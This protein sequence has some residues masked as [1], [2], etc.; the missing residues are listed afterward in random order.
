MAKLEP[1]QQ[2]FSPPPVGTRVGAV[3][4][5]DDDTVHLLGYGERIEDSVPDVSVLG[6][7][8]EALREVDQAIPTIRL[9]CGAVVWACECHW[10]PEASIKNWIGERRV[11]HVAPRRGHGAGR[12]G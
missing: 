6:P 4:S 8:A 7:Q 3:R 12:P 9:D 5:A 1:K 10:A 2:L 11:I